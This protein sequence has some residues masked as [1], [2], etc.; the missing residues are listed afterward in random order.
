MTNK[1]S[2]IKNRNKNK[3]NSITCDKKKLSSQIKPTNVPDFP[4]LW[5]LIISKVYSIWYIVKN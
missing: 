4:D 1:N 3:Y 2:K 5:M